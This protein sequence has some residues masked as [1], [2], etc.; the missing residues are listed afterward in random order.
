MRYLYCAYSSALHEKCTSKGIEHYPFKFGT[1]VDCDDRLDRMNLGWKIKGGRRGAPL[2]M[3]DQWNYPVPPVDGGDLKDRVVDKA[4]K[5]IFGK[6]SLSG[7]FAKEMRD[8]QE[9]N[10]SDY[11]K[12]ESNGVGELRLISVSRWNDHVLDGTCGDA[13]LSDIIAKIARCAFFE[14]ARELGVKE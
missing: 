11:K 9:T 1:A 3:C 7:E 12:F 14:L 10:I 5:K 8:W 13:H 6:W 2:A 4:A